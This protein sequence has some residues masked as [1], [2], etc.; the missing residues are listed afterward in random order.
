[1]KKAWEIIIESD[2]SPEAYPIGKIVVF[3]VTLEEAIDKIKSKYNSKQQFEKGKYWIKEAKM[4]TE[5][6]IE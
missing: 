5:A 2:Y 6:T 4:I 1:M 3:A